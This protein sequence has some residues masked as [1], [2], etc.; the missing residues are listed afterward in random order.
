[1]TALRDMS[2]ML[3][4]RLPPYN[5]IVSSTHS[6]LYGYLLRRRWKPIVSLL[7]HL[8]LLLYDNSKALTLAAAQTL[9][10]I[11]MLDSVFNN[12]QRMTSAVTQ[13]LY[14]EGVL[15]S[16]YSTNYGAL[17]VGIHQQ[18]TSRLLLPTRWPISFWNAAWNNQHWDSPHYSCD[19]KPQHF[20]TSC[21]P[22]AKATRP[23]CGGY[24]SVTLCT[25]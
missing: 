9:V 22:V 15:P 7:S 18:S 5:G 11:I 23:Q 2:F 17:L 14:R 21:A 24:T 3:G 1:M 4:K 10:R 12:L 6:L 20:T 25:T 8:R 13:S 19:K 16:S